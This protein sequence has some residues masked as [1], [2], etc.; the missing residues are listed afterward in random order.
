LTDNPILYGKITYNGMLNIN[1]LQ[2]MYLMCKSH[3]KCYRQAMVNKTNIIPLGACFLASS[4]HFSFTLT[5]KALKSQTSQKLRD[6]VFGPD[7][8]LIRKLSSSIICN[9]YQRSHS[10][11]CS[12]SACIAGRTLD[13][14]DNPTIK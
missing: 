11:Y 14:T 7:I 2:S 9:C 4:R 10:V 6:R 3:C 8:I 5:G 13:K 12:R 1:F